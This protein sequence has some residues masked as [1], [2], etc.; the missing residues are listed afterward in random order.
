M[1]GT[2]LNPA[3][4][5]TLLLPALLAA[6]WLGAAAIPGTPVHVPHAAAQGVSAHYAAGWNLVAAPTGTVLTQAAGTLYTFRP[7]SDSYQSVDRNGIVGGRSVW[8]YF[9]SDTTLTLGATAADFTR[10]I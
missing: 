3:V 8:A 2:H 10:I 4:R 6:L 7:T 9:P 1:T 5:N